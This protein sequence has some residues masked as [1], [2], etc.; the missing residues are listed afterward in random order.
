MPGSADYIFGGFST[1]K[2][3]LLFLQTKNNTR[4]SWISGL[5]RLPLDTQSRKTTVSF[6]RIGLVHQPVAGPVLHVQPF[7]P[8]L[9][10]KKGR[11][12]WGATV[13]PPQDPSSRTLSDSSCWLW[14]SLQTFPTSNHFP[15]FILKL[16]EPRRQWQEGQA[17]LRT[18]DTLEGL[19]VL[20][21]PLLTQMVIRW[22]P[23]WNGNTGEVPGRCF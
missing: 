12:A 5:K 20:A 17:L 4:P 14:L 6:T 21:R 23:E 9:S 8:G 3:Y 7:P 2:F 22:G 15:L 1:P 13:P 11:T 16:G 19:W 18:R 10:L